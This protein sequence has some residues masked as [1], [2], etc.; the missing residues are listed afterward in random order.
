[1]F[2]DAYAKASGMPIAPKTAHFWEI[3]GNFRWGVITMRDARVY[4]EWRPP[5]IELA[6]IGRRTAETE[7]ELLNLIGDG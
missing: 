5:S 2:R 6:S 7:L 3:F 1:V 4:R